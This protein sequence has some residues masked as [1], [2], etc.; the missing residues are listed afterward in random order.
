MK[1]LQLSKPHMLIM[2]GIAGSGKS[3]FAEKFADTFQAPLISD[4]QLGR[5][6]ADFG[7][8]SSESDHL[9]KKLTDLQLNELLKTGRT[10]ILDIDSDTTSDR[11]LLAT[12][13]RKNNYETLI[14]WVQTDQ[15]TAIDRVVKPSKQATSRVM[16]KDQYERHLKRFM[17]PTSTENTVVV[18]GR[19]TYAT[20]AKVVLKKLSGPRAENAKIQTVPSREV[21]KQTTPARR[22]ITIR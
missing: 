11:A 6:L 3:F 20:Q 12:K 15:V 13:A 18:S 8:H 19:H 17:P 14:I 2:V 22:N 1:L 9:L 16:N 4:N 21:I 7:L 5:H 10:I